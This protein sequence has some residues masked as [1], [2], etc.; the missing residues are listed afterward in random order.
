MNDIESSGKFPDGAAFERLHE[1]PLR[2][3]VA[4]LLSAD[5]L[6]WLLA[7][8]TVMILRY[9]FG[10]TDSQWSWAVGYTLIAI[11]I[12]SVVSVFLNFVRGRNRVASFDEVVAAAGIVAILIFPLGLLISTLVTDLPRALAVVMPPLAFIFMGAVRGLYRILVTRAKINENG[13]ESASPAI[14]YG[15]GE[16]GRQVAQLVDHADE[17][18]YRIL[19]FVDDSPGKQM[20][21]VR[22]YRVIGTGADLIKIA[23]ETNAKTV[24][25]AV[26]KASA[27]M[28]QRIARECADH[29]LEFVVIPPVREMIGGRMSLDRLRHFNVA[30]LLGR[31]PISTDVRS[32][33]DYVM[34]KRVLVTGAGGSIGSELARQLNRL[35][36]SKL[37]LMDRDES[38]LH[39]VRL[40][41]DGD[42]LLDTDDLVLCDIRERDALDAIFEHHKPEVV[43]HAAALKHL[44]L[45]ERYP[46]EGW[47]TNTL[48]TRNVLAAARQHGV[49]HFVNVSTDKA[50]DATSVLGMTKRLAERLTSWHAQDSGFKYLS[51][52][53]GNVLGSRGSVLYT[54]RAQI[55]RGGPITVT[56][57]DVTRYFMTIPEA[58]ELVLQAGAIGRPGDVL[59]LD[60]GEPVKIVDVAERLIAES[61]KEIEV[62]FTGLRKGEKLHEVL[63]STSEN[64]N[65]SAHSLIRTVSVPSLSPADIPERPKNRETI[66]DLLGE[67]VRS[68]ETPNASDEKYGTSIDPETTVSKGPRRA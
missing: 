22:D 25:L 59:V 5:A 13:K 27:S 38:E 31:R 43:F 51:V 44:P 53:F 60:M 3:K 61:G 30:D 36:P 21:R 1:L 10:L 39:A 7:L 6:A 8:V 14:V 65:E 68:V 64:S 26:T 24:I 32:I 4:M 19:G 16:A 33:A 52:R 67:E 34:G 23:T 18:P 17:S 41:I 48:G 55:E 11:A 57:P 28:I 42:G 29:G 2:L 66:H 35:G 20:L 37:L 49:E 12:Q 62:H 46:L 15:A 50:A 63:F 54:F 45:L 9:D 47:K 58:C 40:S 56:D